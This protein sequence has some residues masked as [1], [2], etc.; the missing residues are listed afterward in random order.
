MERTIVAVELDALVINPNRQAAICFVFAGWCALWTKC[1]LV[2]VP[3]RVDAD[4]FASENFLSGNHRE[5]YT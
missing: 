3:V 1:L 5:L 4:A 2:A